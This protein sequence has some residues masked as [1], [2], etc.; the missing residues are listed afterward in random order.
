MILTCSECKTNFLISPEILGEKGKK[1]RC[2][3]C[4]YVWHQQPP[5]PEIKKAVEQVKKEQEA[6]L[7]KAVKEKAEGKE[8]SLPAVVEEKKKPRLKKV[9]VIL[10][11]LANAATFAVTQKDKIGDFEIPVIGDYNTDS[12]II[13]NPQILESKE[14]ASPINGAKT[15][16]HY[17]KWD[18]ANQNEFQSSFPAFKVG[19]YDE[20]LKQISEGNKNLGGVLKPK[21]IR[22]L[23][24][25]EVSDANKMG[26]Y[27]IVDIGSPIELMKR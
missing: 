27:I 9:A 4:A 26:S 3:N 7:K 17:V 23:L 8:P 25:V 10:L 16:T 18:I 22:K 15:L 12:V 11:V 2:G 20:N 21:E 19:L 6:N 14:I 5:S 24:P 13:I 1:V